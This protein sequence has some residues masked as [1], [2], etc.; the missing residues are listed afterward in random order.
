VISFDLGTLL[1]ALAPLVGSVLVLV[2]DVVDPRGQRVHYAIACISL[3]VGMVGTVGAL[4]SPTGDDLR[5]L[6]L[7]GG[8]TCFYAATALTTTLQLASLVAAVVT[9]LLAWPTERTADPGRTAV[10]VALLLAATAGAVGVAGARDLASWLVTLELAT[11]PVVTL[12]ALPGTRRALA[13]AVQLLTT[14]LVSFAML[15]LAAACWYAATGSPVLGAAP[16]LAATSTPQR[17]LLALAVVLVLGGIAFKLSLAPFH[18]WTPTTY[19]GSPLPVTVFLAGVSKVAALA[20]LLVVVS[21]VSA[22]GRSALVAVAVL[23]VGSMTLGN[24]MALRQDDVVRLLAWSTVAQAG[25]VVVPLLSISSLGARAAAGY[26]LTYLVATLVAFTAVMVTVT[27]PGGPR[28]GGRRLDAYR[29]LVRTHP[30]A[31][32]ALLLALTS[33]AG[34]PPG[35]LGLVG[36][37]VALRPVLAEGWWVVAVLAAGNVVLGVAVYLRWVRVLV[38]DAGP[39]PERLLEATSAPGRP[40][41][42]MHPSHAVALAIGTTLLVVGSVQPQLLL[43]LLG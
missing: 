31:A 15:A 30:W 43:G 19:A 37:I 28:R 16:A 34:L 27:G 24:L 32:G 3:V 25:W 18:A 36:K 11:L 26:L 40:S 29:G 22:L 21:A 14:S 6:C 9:L 7:P 13:G 10:T 5:T 41:R 17:A 42:R 39:T 35:V 23:A 8:G 12:A 20:A 4:G 33:L 2:L 1:P 38:Q